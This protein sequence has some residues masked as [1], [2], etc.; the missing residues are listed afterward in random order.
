MEDTEKL[1]EANL[2]SVSLRGEGSVV[3]SLWCFTPRRTGVD[4]SLT[5]R[6]VSLLCSRSLVL[7]DPNILNLL[8]DFLRKFI[9]IFES[10]NN[11]MR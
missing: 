3:T 6:S 4:L 11:E 1:L 5:L 7:K 10:E 2:D 8:R 9:L